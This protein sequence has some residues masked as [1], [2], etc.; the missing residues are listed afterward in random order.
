MKNTVMT[1]SVY[2]LLSCEKIDLYEN[3]VY[4]VDVDDR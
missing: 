2:C 1:I 4:E 3:T